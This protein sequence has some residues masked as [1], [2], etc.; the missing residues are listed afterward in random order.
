[1]RPLLMSLRLAGLVSVAMLA[2]ATAAFAQAASPSLDEAKKDPILRAM[3]EELERSRTHLHFED[4]QHPFFI[5]YRLDDMES[6]EAEASYGA[7]T[8][9]RVD[10]RRIVRVTV[11]VGDYKTDSSALRG[12]RGDGSLQIAA[13]EDDPVA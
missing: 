9:E 2:T 12:E 11:R 7:L 6:F 1:M 13:V 8:R 4:W 3:L 10:H 5:Q